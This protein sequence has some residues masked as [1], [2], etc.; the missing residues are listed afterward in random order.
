MA[1][2]NNRFFGVRQFCS[3]GRDVLYLELS[4]VWQNAIHL[5]FELSGNVCQYVVQYFSHYLW[6]IVR[7]MRNVFD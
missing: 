2:H 3:P 4:K 1:W 7:L 6:R 5:V